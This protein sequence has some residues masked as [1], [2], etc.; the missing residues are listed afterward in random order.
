VTT[1][2]PSDPDWLPFE[3]DEHEPVLLAIDGKIYKVVGESEAGWLL[4]IPLTLFLAYKFAGPPLRP[5][6]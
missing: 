1:E 3:P 5:E 6:V 4:A 2:I